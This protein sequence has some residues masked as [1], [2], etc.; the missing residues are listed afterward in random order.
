MLTPTAPT[1]QPTVTDDHLSDTSLGTRVK[2]CGIVEP[3]EL[4]VLQL[5]GLTSSGCGGGFRGARTTSSS[6]NGASSRR[7]P[8]PPR[9]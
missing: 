3:T 9:A 2:V 6:R 5:V 8:P 4:D 7:R 1:S